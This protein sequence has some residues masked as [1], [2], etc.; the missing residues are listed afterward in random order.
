MRGGMQVEKQI[1]NVDLKAKKC[2]YR[3]EM[4]VFLHCWLSSLHTSSLCLLIVN[5]TINACITSLIN[6]FFDHK[7]LMEA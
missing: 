3:L 4:C 1:S 7:L 6:V 2:Q 5:K